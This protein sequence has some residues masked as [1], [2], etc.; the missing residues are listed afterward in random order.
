M[1][2]VSFPSVVV[3]DELSN[4]GVMTNGH[5]PQKSKALRI[6]NTGI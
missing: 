5:T 2:M 6:L 4:Q 1:K 3:T